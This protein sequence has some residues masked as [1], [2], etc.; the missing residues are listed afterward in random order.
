MCP[1]T[2]CPC[3]SGEVVGTW[4]KTKHLPSDGFMDC[5]QQGKKLNHQPGLTQNQC[6]DCMTKYTPDCSGF[7]LAEVHED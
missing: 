1:V 6:L 7:V 4:G 2:T 5:T 3:E